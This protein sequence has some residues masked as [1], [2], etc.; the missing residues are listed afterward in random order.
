M[1]RLCNGRGFLKLAEKPPCPRCTILGASV[2]K[3]RRDKKTKG[4]ARKGVKSLLYGEVDWRVEKNA[5][6]ARKL[7]VTRQAVSAFRIY[8][9]KPKVEK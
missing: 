5:D 3:I 4:D 6:I 1:C 2:Y 8:H 9:Q 7:G